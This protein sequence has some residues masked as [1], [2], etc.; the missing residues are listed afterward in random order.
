V[1]TQG[2]HPAVAGELADRVAQDLGTDPLY[3]ELAA[4]QFVVA[5]D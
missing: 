1:V 2:L 4:T 5:A 3:A